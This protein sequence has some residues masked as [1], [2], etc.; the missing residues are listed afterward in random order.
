VTGADS[1][2]GLEAVALL[3]TQNIEVS[4]IPVYFQY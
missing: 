4:I 2:L 1:G 3:A